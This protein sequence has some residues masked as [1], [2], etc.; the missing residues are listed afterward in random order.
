MLL[1]G[2]PMIDGRSM[3]WL[4]GLHIAV[5]RENAG[6]LVSALASLYIDRLWLGGHK[7]KP[8]P[9]YHDNISG[10]GDQVFIFEAE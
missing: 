5:G 6:S 1:I 8:L 3:N 4:S 7:A 2:F 10:I 9:N